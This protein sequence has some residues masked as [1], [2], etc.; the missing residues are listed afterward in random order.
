MT[1]G[2]DDWYEREK[3][4]RAARDG[5]L[6][7]VIELM[8]AGS[9]PNIF[10]EIGKTPLHYAVEKEHLEMVKYL[11]THGANVNAHDEASI[12][13]TP[14]ADVA[15]TCSLQMAQLLVNAG[16]DPTITGW[17]GLNALD[18]AR[19]RKRVEGQ[20]VYELFVQV[21]GRHT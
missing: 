4:H 5:D 1:D 18:R 2:M 21:S 19:E 17:M 14:I 10:D 6:A 16:A 8:K 3:L 12:G 11:V 20:R 7:R 9:D 13:N 15:A